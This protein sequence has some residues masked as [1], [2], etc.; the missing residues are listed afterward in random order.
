MLFGSNLL[1]VVVFGSNM[2]KDN[3]LEVGWTPCYKCRVD[4]IVTVNLWFH[5]H[6]SKCGDLL[7]WVYMKDKEIT[8][9]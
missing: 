2:S 4:G 5:V 9:K 7:V 3:E 8:I 1:T 6:G